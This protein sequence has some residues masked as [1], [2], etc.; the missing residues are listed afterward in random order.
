MAGARNDESLHSRRRGASVTRVLDGT[1]RR[2]LGIAPCPSL[3]SVG[4]RGSA[5]IAKHFGA[6]R[7][8]CGEGSRG[9]LLEVWENLTLQQRAR[10]SRSS[11]GEDNAFRARVRASLRLQKSTG[12][13]SIPRSARGSALKRGEVGR[14][15]RDIARR[16]NTAASGRGKPRSA[17]GRRRPDRRGSVGIGGE[18]R[19]ICGRASSCD[20]RR[21]GSR[22]PFSF[23]EGAA[24]PI[25]VL[26]PSRCILH[27]S[28]NRGHDKGARGSIQRHASGKTTPRAVAARSAEANRSS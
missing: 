15:A 4:P 13:V 9:L 19:Q 7:S 21:L 24:E 20:G 1:A 8:P 10:T 28:A 16:G 12:V 25:S 17:N 2:E 23:H 11:A 5:S 27:A 26:V 6:A 18:E 22:K 14:V 3:G